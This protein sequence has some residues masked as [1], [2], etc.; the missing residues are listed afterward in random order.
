MRNDRSKKTLKIV[1][2]GPGV[3]GGTTNMLYIASRCVPRAEE[4]SGLYAYLDVVKDC[5]TI[6]STN[7]NRLGIDLFTQGIAQ[8]TCYRPPC[9]IYRD[10][11]RREILEG[12]DGVIFVAD[13]QIARMEANVEM[14]EELELHLQSYGSTLSSLPW[15]IQY[16]KRDLLNILS[17]EMLEVRLNQDHVPY[18]EAISVKGVGVIETLTTLLQLLVPT[19]KEE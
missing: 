17:V 14:M 15:V 5:L 9:S 12:V 4:D 13:S 1:Y 18:V 11:R 10:P 2:Y 6:D 16:N 7:F 3:A 8:I 19:I